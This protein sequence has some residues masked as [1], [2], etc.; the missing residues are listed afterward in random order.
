M[1]L[2]SDIGGTSTRPAYFDVRDGRLH[3]VVLERFPSRDHGGLAEIV[4]A[5]GR[6]IR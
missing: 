5:S 3:P 2:A 4:A 1:I 6:R